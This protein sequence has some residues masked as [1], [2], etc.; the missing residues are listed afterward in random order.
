MVRSTDTCTAWFFGGNALSPSYNRL[1]I[2]VAAV[3]L[4][5]VDVPPGYCRRRF[6]T[7]SRIHLEYFKRIYLSFTDASISKSDERRNS[8]AAVFVL[9][10]E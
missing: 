4:T 8:H 2:I 7:T 10:L 3:L 5:T 1:I 9:H 6:R